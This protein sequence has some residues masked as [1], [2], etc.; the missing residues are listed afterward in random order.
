MTSLTKSGL[1]KIEHIEPLQPIRQDILDELY[2][3]QFTQAPDVMRKLRWHTEDKIDVDILLKY[4]VAY[5]PRNGTII[6]PH[7]NV[8][9]KIVGLYE[10]N[11]RMLR[12]DFYKLYPGA[13]FQAAMWFPRAKYV[14]LIR[15]ENIGRCCQMKKR[16]L[17]VSLIA[18]ICTGCTLLLLTLRKAGKRS[19]LRVPSR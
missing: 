3:E 13:P 12:K 8:N 9:G 18:L 4:D 7:H 10:R 11:F 1:F 15:D 16:L 6:L 19:Y 14:P 2:E 5:F 17:G